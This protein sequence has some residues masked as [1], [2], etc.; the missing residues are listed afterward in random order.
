[1][2]DKPQI[3]GCLNRAVEALENSSIVLSNLKNSGEGEVNEYEFH[4]EI[5]L[6]SLADLKAFR[7]ALPD[8][9]DK[10]NDRDFCYQN[11]LADNSGSCMTLTTTKLTAEALRDD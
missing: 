8:D 11:G 10:V 3:K 1:M 7:D 9:M 6:K 2:N 4:L 5:N